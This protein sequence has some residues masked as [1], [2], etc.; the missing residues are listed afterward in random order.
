MRFVHPLWFFALIGLIVLWWLRNRSMIRST[1]LYSRVEALKTL[2]HK[3]TRL[4]S[5]VTVLLRFLVFFLIIIAL[6][7]PQSVLQDEEVTTEGLDIMLVL[8]VSQS[9]AAEDFNPN[10]LEAAKKTIRSFVDKRVYDRLGLVV[11]G[12][13]AY[14]QCP[15]TAD[16]AVLGELLQS[17][18]LGMA[19]DGTA[20]GMA[21][22]TALNRLKD[23]EGKTK[24][25]ILLTDG[26]NNRG[27]I[28]PKSAS[29][30]ASDLGIKVYTIG[31]GSEKG[32][33]IPIYDPQYGKVYTNQRTSID[34][35][36]L[37]A[38]AKESGASYFRAKD[39]EALVSIYNQIDR[40][41][42]TEI[43][44]T[45]YRQYVDYFPTILLGAF[46][47]LMIEILLANVVLVFIP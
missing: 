35:V 45:L 44:T 16:H 2:D 41:E 32:A 37:K 4:L 26:E 5:S 8:D 18:E 20:V 12:S 38:I 15:L 31:V 27:Q 39:K 1:L 19:G 21:L 30:L 9:M 40:F 47:L 13:D 36:T 43:N 29:K 34:E 17:V 7:R 10:R 42:K 24:L 46:G 28:D 14:T 3:R 25:I 6:A 33:R 11:F 23:S 22:A